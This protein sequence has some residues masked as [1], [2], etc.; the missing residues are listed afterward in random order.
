MPVVICYLT[1]HNSL[2]DSPNATAMST[3]VSAHSSTICPSYSPL[4]SLIDRNC[5]LTPHSPSP[6]LTSKPH[7]VGW[8]T[9]INSNCHIL[10]LLS[11]DIILSLKQNGGS[12]SER[13]FRQLLNECKKIVAKWDSAR[14]LESRGYFR[15]LWGELC[16][17]LDGVLPLDTSS[18]SRWDQLRDKYME[19]ANE[20]PP[21]FPSEW[22]WGELRVKH[23]KICHSAHSNPPNDG[24]PGRGPGSF[25]YWAMYASC[26]RAVIRFSANRSFLGSRT[27]IT[28]SGIATV[29]KFIG[30]RLNSPMLSP[31]KS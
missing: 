16:F 23:T 12:L 27:F 24:I 29:R 14:T 11:S 19:N 10:T 31:A 9:S 2:N 28:R 13:E 26:H 21:P 25:Y 8:A 18:I 17:Q 3:D 7:T 5:I 22:G 4:S 30:S 1:H 20:S 15:N 6:C